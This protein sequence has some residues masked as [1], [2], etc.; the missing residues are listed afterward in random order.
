MTADADLPIAVVAESAPL[1]EAGVGSRRSP[2]VGQSKTTAQAAGGLV[3]PA[4]SPVRAHLRPMFLA[5]ALLP[6]L[7]VAAILWLVPLNHLSANRTA[8]AARD[9][10]DMWAAGHFA[11]IGQTDLFFDPPRFAAAL[12]GMFGAGLPDQIWPYPPPALLL[13]VPLSTLPLPAG[14]LLYTFAT[15]GLLWW[16]LRAGRMRLAACGSVLFSPAVAENALAGQNGALLSACLLGGLLVVDRRPFIAGIMLGALILK[17]QLGLLVPVCLVASGNWRALAGLLVSASVLVGLSAVLFGLG[18][19]IGFFL[20]TRPIVAAVI[21]APWVGSPSQQIFASPLMA[22]RSVGIST[23]AAYA[24][25][26]GVS[27]TCAA[28]A[29]RT[30]RFPTIDPLLR[31]SLIGVLSLMAAPWVHTYDMIPLA[32]AVVVMS[33]SA[34]KPAAALLAYAWFWPGATTLLSLPMPLSVATLA[35]VGWLAWRETRRPGFAVHAP[36]DAVHA[37]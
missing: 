17:P 18:P 14:F 26:T 35:L 13:A 20:H 37:F 34:P 27:L 30:W 2:R 29:W 1:I 11:R 10:T 5:V 36:S 16:A 12:R 32:V 19:W 31:A 21:A 8:L 25:Q 24:L 4:G 3:S 33:S 9:Y 22:A 15:I 23:Q 7:F 6:S 28:I